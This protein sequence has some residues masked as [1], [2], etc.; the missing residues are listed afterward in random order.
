MC[1]PTARFCPVC[2]LIGYV[3]QSEAVAQR[4]ADVFD[5][6]KGISQ[7]LAQRA[8]TSSYK[9]QEHAII[10]SSTAAEEREKN[11]EKSDDP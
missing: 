9:P 4:S 10:D 5:L 6:G 1:E 2:S 11:R 7:H 8:H 3:H